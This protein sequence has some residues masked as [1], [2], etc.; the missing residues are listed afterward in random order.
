VPFTR[1]WPRAGL[2]PV[3]NPVT[4]CGVRL[5]TARAARLDGPQWFPLLDPAYL[6]GGAFTIGDEADLPLALRRG[7]VAVLDFGGVQLGTLHLRV[8]ASAATPAAAATTRWRPS[9][10]SVCATSLCTHT[11]N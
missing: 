6:D 9:R 5:G 8:T 2:R 3:G 11:V 1:V 4:P 7:E 10:R